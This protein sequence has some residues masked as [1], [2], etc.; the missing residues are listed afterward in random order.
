M[1]PAIQIPKPKK[2]TMANLRRLEKLVGLTICGLTW[3]ADNENESQ[4]VGLL[5]KDRNGEK[6]TLWMPEELEGLDLTR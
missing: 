3:D 4:T 2:Q 5:L 1:T 6:Y